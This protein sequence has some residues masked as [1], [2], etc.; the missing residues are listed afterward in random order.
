MQKEERKKEKESKKKTWATKKGHIAPIFVPA[1][2]GG[3]LTREL[4]KIADEESK[5][6]IHFNVLE[7]GGRTLRSEIQRSNPTATPGCSKKDCLSCEEE[8]GKEENAT[9]AI[10]TTK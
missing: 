4:R 9:R 10:S 1:T 6:G 3:E 5:H 7:I 2:P 8:R